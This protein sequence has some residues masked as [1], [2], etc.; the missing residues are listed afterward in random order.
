MSV[1]ASPPMQ[2]SL[3]ETD[4]TDPTRRN[5]FYMA[6]TWLRWLQD[7]L[8]TRLQSAPLDLKTVTKTAQ[9]AAIGAT[10]VP[11]GSVSAGRYQITWYARI[12]TPD[13]VSSSL[14]VTIAWTEG[15][16]SLSVSGSAITGNTTASLQS[17]VI[18]VDVDASSAISYA[19]AYAS[20]T[21]G[22]MQY[23]LSVTVKQ[24]P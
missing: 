21:P 16:V 3:V 10:A 15:A 23:R 9:S 13:A 2:A 20:N 18:E 1:I 12:T 24:I 11:L 4:E 7:S 6:S 14:T 22:A 5:P 17:G 19:T 8:V